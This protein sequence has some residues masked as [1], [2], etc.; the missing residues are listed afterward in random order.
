MSALGGATTVSGLARPESAFAADAPQ[1]P[2]QI[3][4]AIQR[5]LASAPKDFAPDFVRNAVPPFFLTS[6]HVGERP[7]LPTPVK[8]VTVSIQGLEKRGENN[9]RRRICFSAMTRTSMLYAANV[10][11]RAT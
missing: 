10:K 4:A 3:A 1:T 7:V 8:G 2:D 11:T 9:R 6:F 5:M